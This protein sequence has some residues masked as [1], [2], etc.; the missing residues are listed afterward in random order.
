MKKQVLI[1][2]YEGIYSLP[3]VEAFLNNPNAEVVRILRS[4]T[5]FGNKTG[6]DGMRYLLRKS[7]LLFIV[8]KF[9]ET[10]LCM[11]YTL[12]PQGK[13][14]FKTLDELGKIYGVPV[15]TIGDVNQYPHENFKGMV[16]FSSYFN[17]V[18]KPHI[19]GLYEKT[20]NIH[21]APLPAGRGLF[22]QFWLLLNPYH[23]QRYYQTIHEMTA[24]IDA[25]T[26]IKQRSVEA[27][28]HRPSMADYMNKVTILGIPMMREFDF[29]AQADIHRETV[30]SYNSFPRAKDVLK[31]WRKG[32]RF[33]TVRDV[34]NFFQIKVHP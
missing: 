17:Q 11:L 15:E 7:S 10:I 25:G 32:C 31:F 6:L 12:L 3:L 20:Y 1:V 5:I 19:L 16:L 13:R 26:I 34:R 23:T 8:P 14:P 33:L 22:S 21:P 2:T 29:T 24:E 9:F 30:G 28:I 18:F 4:G 27:T